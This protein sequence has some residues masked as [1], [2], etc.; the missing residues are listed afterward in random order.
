[1][2][3]RVIIE[4]GV[5]AIAPDASKVSGYAVEALGWASG[6]GR[7]TGTT[8]GNSVILKPQGN[9]FFLK[10]PGA[11]HFSVAKTACDVV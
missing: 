11:R 8:S 9:A 4:P 6:N 5:T 2:S 10:Q 7:I 3:T 1:M